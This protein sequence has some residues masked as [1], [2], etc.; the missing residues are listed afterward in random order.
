MEEKSTESNTKKPEHE[1][2]FYVYKNGT[3]VAYYQ[4]NLNKTTTASIGFRVPKIDVPYQ[5]EKVCVYNGEIFYLSAE[6]DETTGKL[7]LNARKPIILPGIWHKAEHVT[8]TNSLPE[9]D[10]H[11]I[12][13]F[14]KRTNTICGAETTQ[15][16]VKYDINCPTKY[17]EEVFELLSKR[18]FRDFFNE[19][20]FRAENR[21]IYQEL[22]MGLDEITP[23]S[24]IDGEGRLTISDIVGI[25]KK[26]IESISSKKVLQA[27][28]SYFTKENMIITVASD[29]PYS[30]IEPLIK[31]YFIDKAP[32]IPET[33]QQ[34]QQDIFKFNGDFQICEQDPTKNTV[35]IDYIIKGSVDYQTNEMFTE[36]ENFILNSFNGRLLNIFREQKGFTYT[37]MFI[38]QKIPGMSLKTF[39][40]QTTPEH[41]KECM[42]LLN[43]TLNDLVY[44]GI[45]DDEFSGFKEMWE[46]RRDRK[47]S[48]KYN[49][50]D[51]MFYK[52]VNNE[53]V[54]LHNFF[55]KVRNIKKEDINKYLHDV[56]GKSNLCCCVSGNFK[57]RD[58]LS[59][60]EILQSYR[61]YDKYL[62]DNG[63]FDQSNI[64][65][66]LKVLK[67]EKAPINKSKVYIVGEKEEM[68]RQAQEEL[69][70]QKQQEAIDKLNNDIN[71]AI[72]DGVK[73]KLV[74]ILSQNIQP[75]D[76]TETNT[77]QDNAENNNTANDTQNSA[78]SE[79]AKAESNDDMA[80]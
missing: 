18:I 15:E 8:Y 32:S 54:F 79:N 50:S 35:T 60:Y 26:V 25:D 56:F 23:L 52:I 78:E 16:Y 20:E 53:P 22:E 66:F 19:A 40:V 71:K 30:Q 4:Q 17:L 24:F 6:Q 80:K 75:T 45:T 34:H 48:L 33:K 28:K 13:D 14:F 64:H 61:P 59:I 36:I 72:E 57:K 42:K 12:Q 39:E 67:N 27:I 5:D 46:N 2:G 9:L 44:N 7:V 10:R 58:V 41:L 77:N 76:Q 68:E 69:A 29:L 55:D 51:E 31:K 62:K 1:K 43:K 70:K 11:E 65:E 21:P 37:P 47:S 3:P 73:Q 49:T 74:E 63:F 38:S